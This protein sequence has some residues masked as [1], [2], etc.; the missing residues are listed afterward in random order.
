MGVGY[1][2]SKPS[3][4]KEA[5]SFAYAKV[6]KPNAREWSHWSDLA[7]LRGMLDT[8]AEHYYVHDLFYF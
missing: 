4:S 1:S 2:T 7:C 5:W 6:P 8:H 3:R